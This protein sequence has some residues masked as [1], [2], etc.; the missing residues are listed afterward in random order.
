M[1]LGTG[2]EDTVYAVFARQ[3]HHGVLHYHRDLHAFT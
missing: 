1:Y 2:R 3:F